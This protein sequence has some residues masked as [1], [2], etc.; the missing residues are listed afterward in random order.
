MNLDQAASRFAQGRGRNRAAAE[1]SPAAAI[2]LERSAE[3]QRLAG[4]L[5][6]PRLIEQCERR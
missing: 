5:L 4:F 6:D 2:G 1:E 3:D